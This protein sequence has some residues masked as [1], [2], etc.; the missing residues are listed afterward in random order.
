MVNF[1]AQTGRPLRQL[2]AELPFITIQ[3]P[4]FLTMEMITIVRTVT[5]MQPKVAIICTESVRRVRHRAK[6]SAAWRV[7]WRVACDESRW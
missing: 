5:V 7:E 1:Q 6:A 3:P 4:A 2:N